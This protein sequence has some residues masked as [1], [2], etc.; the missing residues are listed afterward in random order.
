MLA[1]EFRDKM[2]KQFACSDNFIDPWISFAQ[3]NVEL[4][5]Y[6]DF[7]PKEKDHAV[8][9]WLDYLFSSLYFAQKRTD[10]EGFQVIVSLVAERHFCLYHYE[11]MGS[12]PYLKGGDIDSS[13][14]E[15]LAFEGMLDDPKWIPTMDDVE[16]DI[17][18]RKKSERERG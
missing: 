7:K 10:N 17:N 18:A 6:A 4:E 12:I 14:L 15:A 16:K 9:Q 11:I 8:Q 13:Q 1:N 5:H 2:K 3:E